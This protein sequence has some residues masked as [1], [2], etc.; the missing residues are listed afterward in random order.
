MCDSAETLMLSVTS[1]REAPRSSAPKWR[2]GAVPDI[3]EGNHSGGVRDVHEED[4]GGPSLI[5]VLA[6]HMLPGLIRAVLLTRTAMR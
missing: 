3:T 4:W 5:G 1:R 6:F 2:S